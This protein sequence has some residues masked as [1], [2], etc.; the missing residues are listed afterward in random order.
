MPEILCPACN[1]PITVNIKSCTCPAGHNYSLRNNIVDFLPNTDD[2]ILKEEVRHWDDYAMKGKA[3]TEVNSY[4]K[5]KIYN[6]YDDIFYEFI[7]NEWPDYDKKNICVADIGCGSGSAI[8][9]LKNINFAGVDYVGIDVSLHMLTSGDL[10][11]ALTPNWKVRYVRASANTGLFKE[12]S[13]DM[14]FSASALHHLRANDVIKW[15]SK[16]LKC[17][18]LF[19]MHEPTETNPFARLGRKMV[20]DFYTQG[21]KPLNPTK[22]RKIAHE[23]NLDLIYEK[24]LHFLTGPLMYLVQILRFPAPL[25]VLS[26]SVSKVIDRFVVSP[27]WNYSFVQVYR[28]R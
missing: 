5:G 24:G 27:F 2:E 26:Y 7:T 28:R 16:S 14:V 10:Y 20:K 4:I 22:I 25:S 23:H 11:K 9:F 15:V 19:I 6:D 12:S 13:L 18:G 17:G 1:Q 3:S 8:R 21:E